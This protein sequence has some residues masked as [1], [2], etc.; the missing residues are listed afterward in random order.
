MFPV[1]GSV[2]VD[3]D[4]LPRFRPVTELTFTPESSEA[5]FGIRRALFLRTRATTKS[6]RI[7]T[8][9][10]MHNDEICIPNYYGLQTGSTLTNLKEEIS[11]Q[12]C[13]PR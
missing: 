4:G 6:M 11:V 1:N 9:T 8:C 3:V 13:L 10:V 7:A 2:D 12:T 5:P